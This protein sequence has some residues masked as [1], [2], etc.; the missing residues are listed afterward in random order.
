M[1]TALCTP[2]LPLVKCSQS[3]GK[4]TGVLECLCHFVL[5]YLFLECSDEWIDHRSLYSGVE[6]NI[7]Y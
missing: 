7:L 6:L 1:K 2:S 3:P 4:V 5:L